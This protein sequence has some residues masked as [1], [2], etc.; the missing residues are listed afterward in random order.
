MSE[1]ENYLNKEMIDI[2]IK[3][4]ENQEFTDEKYCT[5]FD[6][7]V[8]Q[9]CFLSKGCRYSKNGSCIICDYG[10]VR[11]EN[12]NNKEIRE[13][14]NEIFENLKVKPKVLLL[15][16]LGSV[17]D[18]YEMSLENIETLLEELSKIDINVIIFETHYLSINEEILSLIKSKMPNKEIIIEL[19]LESSNKEIREKCLNK[20]IDNDKFI[21]KINLIKSFGFGVETNIVFGIPFLTKDE[22]SKDT[23]DSIK[24]CLENDIDKVNLFP[25]NIKPYTLLYKLYEEG[26]YMPVLHEDFIITLKFIPE[27]YIDRIYLCWYGNREI[28][29]NGDKT[30]LPVCDK[31]RCND[32]MKFYKEFNL[33]RNKKYRK[34]LLNNLS[35][36]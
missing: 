36:F 23:I 3:A 7:K 30:I 24:W 9:I 27:E 28:D 29:Y 5:F 32:I 1:L 33:N 35:I 13:C 6:G 14:I 20:Y 26:K 19:G 25:V 10:R 16:S 15:N 18:L 34:K 2:H 12:L 21:E 11:K 17:L 8:L 31:E 22:Q 4:R